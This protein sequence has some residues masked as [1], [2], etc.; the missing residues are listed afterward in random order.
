MSKTN[1]LIL[2]IIVPVYNAERYLEECLRSLFV[3]DIPAANY[4]VIAVDNG[5]RDS[6]AA[7]IKT[8]QSEYSNLRVVTL[9]ENRLPSGGRNAG[10]DAA[11]GKYIMFVDSDDYLNP[12]VLSRLVDEIEKDY[13][14]IVHFSNDTLM[15]GAIIKEQSVPTTPVMSGVDLF[16]MD[17]KMLG[18]SWSKIY[19]RQFL[20]DNQLRCNEALLY[21]DDE[22]AYRL[23][24]Y[25][26]RTRHIGFSPYVYRANPYSATCNR[27]NMQSMTSD[28]HAITAFERD[29]RVFE[30]KKV[31]ERLIEHLKKFVRYVIEICYQRYHQFP[32]EQQ[33]KLKQIYRKTLTWRMLPYMSTKK[34]ILLKLNIIR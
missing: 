7:I 17:L 3:Q 16:F 8:L 30:Q 28:M 1:E 22:F 18:V 33:K 21:E 27:I 23:Y 10:M 19:N 34:W 2:S 12:N 5:S 24:A 29:V 4:E 26:K 31:D 11:K 6:S 32:E 9:A 13:L 20:A 25:A 14:D 15:E